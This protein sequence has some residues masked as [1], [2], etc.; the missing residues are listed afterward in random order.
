MD[1]SIS[2]PSEGRIRVRSR[3]LFANPAGLHCR[4]FVERVLG[5][6]GVS[7]V[8]IQGQGALF[9]SNMV[10]I[11]YCPNSYSRQ[12]AIAAIYARLVADNGLDSDPAGGPGAGAGNGSSQGDSGGAYPTHGN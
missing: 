9:G 1:I 7:S 4:R 3:F 11:R 8:S 2:F 5:V 12:Q 6:D 10:E